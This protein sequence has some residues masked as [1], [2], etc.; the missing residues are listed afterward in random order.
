MKVRDLGV[1]EFKALVQEA[2]EEKLEEIL[3]D[4]DQGLELQ[5]ALKKRLEHSV[6]AKSRGIPAE[7]VAREMDLEW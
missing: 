1:E 4:P 6:S 7:D 3:G 5:E 2:V